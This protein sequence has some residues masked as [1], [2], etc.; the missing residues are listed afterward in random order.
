M[1]KKA[2]KI[3]NILACIKCGHLSLIW[4]QKT[5]APGPQSG[6]WKKAY[7]MVKEVMV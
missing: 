4:K 1:T 6:G 3:Q 2:A 7:F 5:A